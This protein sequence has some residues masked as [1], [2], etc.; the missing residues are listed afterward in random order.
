MRIWGWAATVAAASVICT[1]GTAYATGNVPPRLMPASMVNDAW[2]QEHCTGPANGRNAKCPN[3][4]FPAVDPMPVGTAGA[5][6]AFGDSYSSGEGAAQG[7]FTVSCEGS[8]ATNRGDV[9]PFLRLFFEPPKCSSGAEGQDVW[10]PTS[11]YYEGTDNEVNACHRSPHAYPPRVAAAL[12]LTL[13]FRACSGAISGDFWHTRDALPG[14]SPKQ[15]AKWNREPDGSLLAPQNSAPI[16]ADTRLVT[17]GFGGNNAHFSAAVLGCMVTADSF[18]TPGDLPLYYPDVAEVRELAG[19]SWNQNSCTNFVY[20]L[21]SDLPATLGLDAVASP[22]SVEGVYRE[23]RL[24]APREARVLVIGYPRVFPFQ[25]E[26]SC[27]MGTGEAILNEDEQRALNAFVLMLNTH[28][29][30]AATNAGVEYVDI[31]NAYTPLGA[32][33][34]SLEDHG[35]CRDSDPDRWIQ[36]F[37][38]QDAHANVKAVAGTAHPTPVGQEVAAEAV[39]TCY[40]DPTKCGNYDELRLAEVVAQMKE[41][42]Y[43]QAGCPSRE[44]WVRDGQPVDVWDSASVLAEQRDVT[45]DNINEIIVSLS[46]P[47]MTSAWPEVVV[48][49]DITSSTPRHLL[50]I[51]DYYFRGSVR[52]IFAD[53]ITVEGPTVGWDDSNCCPNHWARVTYVW[54]DGGF[55]QQENIEIVNR[56]DSSSTQGQPSVDLRQDLLPD[57]VH[58]AILRGATGSRIAIDPVSVHVGEEARAACARDGVPAEPESGWCVDVYIANSDS[59]IQSLEVSPDAELLLWDGNFDFMNRSY[60]IAELANL[61]QMGKLDGTAPFYEVTT[62][63][64]KV[65]AIEE[66]VWVS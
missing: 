43:A 14:L 19:D 59:V 35:M 34:G 11:G 33:A 26:G 55:Q 1:A 27:G 61:E 8:N 44:E 62:Q 60:P 41:L 32:K 42:S 31:E 2:V 10:R 13:D 65:V 23:V 63:G 28:I 29:K 16:P 3:P 52:S 48:I 53:R 56:P 46:C 51:D 7:V 30:K 50:T 4:G 66:Q 45:A 64:G 40:R 20:K 18:D 58:T 36:R 24:R 15:V 37:R 17:V 49:W 47:A 39:R 38:V 22:G 54:A 9:A 6:V 57:R 25:P 5:M 12:N 21:Q